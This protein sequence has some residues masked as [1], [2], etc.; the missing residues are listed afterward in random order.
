VSTGAVDWR[1][2]SASTIGHYELHA[3]RYRDGTADHDV[4]Q[5]IDALLDALDGT[6]PF[7]I[8]D[9]GCGP[10]R[11][12]AEFSARGHRAVGLDGSARFVAMARES[13]GCEVWCQ[14]F[15]GLA[16]PT[17]RFDG[18]FANATL[19]HVPSAALP[20]VLAAL[21]ATLKPRG[22]LFASN[23]RGANQEGWNGERYGVY[24]DLARWRELLAA[25]GFAELRH[26][27]RP[28]GLPPAQQPWL[29]SVWRAQG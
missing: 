4:T 3:E 17:A 29:A 19:F 16:L 23:P 13:S 15:L 8:L 9:F 1:A 28:P 25:A 12:L 6:A 5:N 24:Y 11:D 22:V 2:T 21:R 18:V 14:D 20:A 26:Y 10:G 7:E 27:Y